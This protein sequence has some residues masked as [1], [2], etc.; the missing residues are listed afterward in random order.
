MSKDKGGVRFS[1][2]KY[3]I[4]R[5]INLLYSDSRRRENIFSLL[6][7][8]LF[9]VFLIFFSRN[10]VSE[11]LMRADRAEAL[12]R[13]RQAALSDIRSE[14]EIYARVRAE[15]SHYGNGYL[16][17]EERTRQD[18]I[19]MLNILDSRVDGEVQSIAIIDNTANITVRLSE[20]DQ[21]STIIASLEESEYVSYVTAS[22]A[23]TSDRSSYNNEAE[24]A[25][26]TAQIT[27][28]FRSPS[29]LAAAV[30]GGAELRDSALDALETAF[31]E[32]AYTPELAEEQ[33]DYSEREQ[34]GSGSGAGQKST[35]AEKPAAVRRAPTGVSA[36]EPLKSTDAAKPTES[37]EAAVRQK[38][39]PTRGAEVQT[40]SMES[41]EITS[42][43][44]G[45]NPS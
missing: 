29:E 11:P 37:T 22:T 21:L 2:G 5:G 26:I 16:N 25:Y 3:P 9:M 33:E 13:E 28:Y 32:N 17:E 19:T 7:F 18:R 15:Y 35:E 34:G 20:G 24:A 45:Y 1:R 27:V 40:P 43:K 14:N 41:S 23:A 6:L 42:L 30:L 39:I 36:E 12:Y 38:P 10:Y 31:G 4:K 44:Q 8:S